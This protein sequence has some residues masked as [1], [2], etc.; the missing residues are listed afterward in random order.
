MANTKNYW[1]Q[2]TKISNDPNEP[3]ETDYKRF[4]CDTLTEVDQVIDQY[5][6]DEG[7]GNYYGSDNGSPLIPNGYKLIDS[8]CLADFKV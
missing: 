5:D 1:V 4:E 7:Y 3:H 2:I 8:G 6:E